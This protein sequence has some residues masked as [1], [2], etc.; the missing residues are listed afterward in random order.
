MAVG[1]RAFVWAR[2]GS[3]LGIV[4]LAAW[5]IQHVWDN[6][7]AF[8]GA[9]RWESAVTRDAHPAIQVLLVVFVIG[10]LVVHTVW[11]IGR[12]FT[13]RPNNHRYGYYAN[14]KYLL[15]RLSAV[16]VLLFLGAH[17]WLAW[18]RPRLVLGHPETFADISREMRF[19]GPTLL[20]YILGTLGVAYHL[21]NGISGFAMGWGVA[22]ARGGLRRLEPIAIG[23]FLAL[24]GMSWAAIY[25]LWR[26]G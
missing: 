12:L 9:E 6:L 1:R 22:E 20:V 16:G 15:Q 14:L 7:A 23:V 21:G 26:A 18:L 3:L 24:L 17:L 8:Q 25:A 2:V 4:P 10:P 11:G 13:A 19:H 5:T